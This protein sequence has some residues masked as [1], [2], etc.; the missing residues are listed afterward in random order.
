VSI[1]E[2]NKA[3]ET[4]PMQKLQRHKLEMNNQFNSVIC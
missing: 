4:K 2:E 3:D 1:D